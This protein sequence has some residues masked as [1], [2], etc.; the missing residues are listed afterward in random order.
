[1]RM[2]RH[3]SLHHLNIWKTVSKIEKVQ[4]LVSFFSFVM[5]WLV[6][7]R[8]SPSLD[9][10]YRRLRPEG[11]RDSAFL[12]HHP[13][14]PPPRR[15][16]LAQSLLNSFERSWLISDELCSESLLLYNSASLL[17]HSTERVAST[18]FISRT[19]QV[20]CRMLGVEQCSGM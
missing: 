8:G 4:E 19:G 6:E 7:G 2:L 5:G 3:W 10:P 1:M 15:Q 16:I 11:E 18:V 20:D 12:L 13:R 9:R 14:F 17:A